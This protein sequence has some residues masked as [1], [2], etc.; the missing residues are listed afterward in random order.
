MASKTLVVVESPAKAKTINR[1]LGRNYMVEAS[2]G[3]IKDLAKTKLCVDIENDFKP[4][5][6]TIKGKGDIVKKL[7]EKAAKA[8]QV[9]IATDPDREGEAIAWHLAEEIKKKN[10]N[11][12]RVLFNEITKDG[13]KKGIEEPSEI[14]ENLYMSQQARRVMDRLIG[15]K[16]SPFLSRAMLEKTAKALSAGRVQS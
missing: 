13:I 14:N 4:K 9:L 12:K 10:D 11:V 8:G 16:V 6:T 5:Y 2:V 7:K 3:H 1:Y 15:F